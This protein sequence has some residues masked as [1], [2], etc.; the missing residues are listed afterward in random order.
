MAGEKE[1]TFDIEKLVQMMLKD[2]KIH[3]GRW[4]FSVSMDVSAGIFH[5][6]RDGAPRP[7]HLLAFNRLSLHDATDA[8]EDALMVFDASLLNPRKKERRNKE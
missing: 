6:P 3:H 7:A 2:A 1:F 4:V 5:S 8:P